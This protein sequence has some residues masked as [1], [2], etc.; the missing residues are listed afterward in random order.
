V[1]AADGA[2]W[3]LLDLGRRTATWR[4]APYQPAAARARACALALDDVG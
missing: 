3:L 1:Q 2:F 4:R